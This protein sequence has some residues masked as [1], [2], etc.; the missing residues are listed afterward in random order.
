MTEV[1]VSAR[2]ALFPGGVG[3]A[4]VVVRLY[5]SDGAF[6]TTATTDADG[7]AYLGSRAVDDYELRL[8]APAP[9]VFS[10]GTMQAITVPNSANN[11]AFDVVVNTAALSTA[12]DAHLCRCSGYFKDAFGLPLVGVTIAFSEDGSMPALLYY[13]G[14]NTTHAVVPGSRY[15]RT[16]AL[17]FA[18]VDLY[19]TQMYSVIMEGYEAVSRTILVPDLSASSLPDVLFPSVHRI[20]WLENDSVIMPTTAPSLALTVDQVKILDVQT[21]FRSGVVSSGLKDVT[22]E[23]TDTGIVSISVLDGIAT[24]V[25]NGTGTTTIAVTRVTPEAGCGITVY[26]EPGLV[27]TLTVVVSA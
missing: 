18:Q 6:I 4:G 17:G 10:S 23:S 5:T 16:D 14:A 27:G 20:E 25:G 7:L 24:L 22:V 26:P 9:A 2:T 12:T 8:S 13:S 11:Y 21:V 15:V 19:R 1:Y 3:V